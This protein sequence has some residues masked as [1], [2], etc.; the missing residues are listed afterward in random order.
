LLITAEGGNTLIVDDPAVPPSGSRLYLEPWCRVANSCVSGFE[1]V[2]QAPPAAAR[3]EC[4]CD[5]DGP[6]GLLDTWEALGRAG[7]LP[8][9]VHVVELGVTDGGRARCWLDRLAA[10]S[11]VRGGGLHRKV[12]YTVCGPSG[13]VL[14]GA[15]ITAGHPGCVRAVRFD[16]AADGPMPA[17]PDGEVMAVLASSSSRSGA[18]RE[19]IVRIDGRTYRTEARAYLPGSTGRAVAAQLGVPVTVLPGLI[20]RQMR[21]GIRA[22]VDGMPVV[23]ADCRRA[24]L[25][26]VRLA[27]RYV[28]VDLA[29]FEL[30][31]GV[32]GRVLGSV[33]GDRDGDRVRLD[34]AVVSGLAR[35]RERLHPDA[36]VEVDCP[37]LAA[38]AVSCGYRVSRL[39]PP[40]P[41]APRC[42]AAECPS[43]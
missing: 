15:V 36:V 22:V 23:D 5:P 31:R 29:R 32:P 12:V 14:A 3:P 6:A 41:R 1:A 9:T 27:L 30:A 26:G 35:L 17:L 28:A 42:P 19:D 7:R 2:R 34:A 10:T 43:A 13:D 8:E 38:V 4:R 21:R 16:P 37:V 39:G 40:A 18:L 33:L 25:T 24:V 20:E 11:R